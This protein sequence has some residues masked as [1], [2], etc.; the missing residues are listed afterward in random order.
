[1]NWLLVR[2]GPPLRAVRGVI[3]NP[4]IR[5]AELAFLCFNVAEA[6]TWIA[7]LVY[8]F[9]RGGTAATGVVGLVLLVP[10]AIVAPVAAALG[11]RYRRERV[12]AFGYA[13]QAATTAATAAAMLAGLSAVLVY[14]VATVAMATYTTGRPGQHSLLPRL[15]RSPDELTAGNAVS[16]LAEGVGGTLGTIVV[17][18][19]LATS[20]EGVVYAAMATLLAVGAALAFRIRAAGPRERVPGAP[21]PW[22]LVTEAL[23]ALAVIARSPDTRLLVGLAGALTLVWGIFDILLITLAIDVLDIGD[24]G[25]GALHT[26]VGIGV[27]VGAGGSVALVG[28][29]RLAPALLLG[30]AVLGAAIGVLGLVDAIVVAFLASGLVGAAVTLLDVTG[31]TLLQRVVDDSLL[32]RVFGAVETLWMV[33]V[34]I[35]SAVAAGL[36]AAIGLG[37]AFVA[38]GVVMPALTFAALRGLRR[39]DRAAVVPTRQLE[40]L[41]AL[42][43]FSPLPRTDLE[44]VARQLARLDVARGDEIVRQGDV[45]DRFYVVDAGTFDVLTDGRVVSSLGEGDHFGEIALLHDVPR[46]ATVRAGTDGAVW[47]LDQEAFLAAVTGMPQAERAAQAVSAERLRGSRGRSADLRP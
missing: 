26:A 23:Q 2:L 43:M 9:D 19:L 8:A 20:T 29:S 39:L 3:G 7:I 36:D 24:A 46:T 30:A 45:G 5:R 21:G 13:A 4:A 25:V 35:G 42:P 12:V 1:M 11:D 18:I 41:S 10:A 28:R 47:A 40:L 15:A 37:W 32:T 17:T 38:T 16:S 34:G 27:L 6:A 33:G 22:S 31:R 14:A 44:R